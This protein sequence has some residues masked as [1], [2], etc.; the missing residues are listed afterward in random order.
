VVNKHVLISIGMSNTTIEF[1]GFVEAA[2]RDPQKARHL[3][4]VDGVQR[5]RTAAQWA[6]REGPPPGKAARSTEGPWE[7][8]AERM[9]RAEVT[10]QQIQVL[11]PPHCHGYFA[12]R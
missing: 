4:I 10:A 6:G 7:V 9:R 3:V 1:S 12:R 2:N 8:L 5:G 11:W